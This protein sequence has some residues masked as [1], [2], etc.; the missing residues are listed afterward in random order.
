MLLTAGVL[1][2]LVFGLLSVWTAATAVL[3]VGED[4]TLGECAGRG[5]RLYPKFLCLSALAGVMHAAGVVAIFL[6]GRSLVHWA[7]ESPVEGTFYWVTAA[8]LGAGAFLMFCLATLHDHARIRVAATDS[9][10]VQACAWAVAFVA[11]REVRALPLAGLLLAGGLGLWL[12]Y[13]TAGMLIPTTSG[14]G[15]AL[16]LVGGEVLLLGRMFLRLWLLAAET[17]L[18]RAAADAAS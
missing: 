11:A 16:S 13:Q 8:S 2:A 6:L 10:V 4:A 7:A 9:G 15:M 18:Q 14:L 3:A 12:L 1:L 17:E 5:V